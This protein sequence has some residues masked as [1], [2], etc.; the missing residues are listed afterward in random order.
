M[1]NQTSRLDQSSSS[2]TF[3]NDD[4]CLDNMR[5]WHTNKNDEPYKRQYPLPTIA[6][7]HNRIKPRKQS[8]PAAVTTVNTLYSNNRKPFSRFFFNKQKL[9]RN[10]S[11]I[12]ATLV[13]YNNT[14]TAPTTTITK[15]V[16]LNNNT[17]NTTNTISL[18]S[19]SISTTSSL[20]N[21]NNSNNNTNSQPHFVHP[22]APPS[23]NSVDLRSSPT[24]LFPFENES[25]S[26]TSFDVTSSSRR[27]NNN[28]SNRNS[29]NNAQLMLL[30]HQ[31]QQQ[32]EQYSYRLQGKRKY[33]Q[34]TGSNYLLPCDEEEIDRLHLQH[35]MVRFAIQG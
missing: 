1:G 34:I 9:P 13:H 8:S 28:N 30:A 27:L 4:P 2:N 18:N 16:L 7:D 22:L 32:Q 31:Q 21:I 3:I 35:F 17:S 26:R 15:Q 10:N 33:H 14:L 24:A 12:D 23:I 11:C 20:I 19:S 6:S 5:Q 29:L 25:F